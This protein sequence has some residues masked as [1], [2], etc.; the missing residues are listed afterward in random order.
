[1]RGVELRFSRK[2]YAAGFVST[3]RGRKGT[4]GK[5]GGG[6]ASGPAAARR[7]GLLVFGF[8]FVALF[9]I[10]AIAVGVGDPS[11]PSGNAAVVQGTPGDVGQVPAAKVEHAIELAAAQAGEKTTPKPGDP[12]YDETKETAVNSVLE[13]IWIQ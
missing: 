2:R 5:G 3:D 12:K 10:V 13:G 1:A 11:I 8:A 4:S 7:L 6:K 9:V